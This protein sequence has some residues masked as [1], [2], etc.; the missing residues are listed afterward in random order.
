MQVC[1]CVYVF[2][3][4]GTTYHCFNGYPCLTYIAGMASGTS[5]YSIFIRGKVEP[6]VCYHTQGNFDVKKI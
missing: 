5:G 6:H 3:A 2:F 1:Q 4:W